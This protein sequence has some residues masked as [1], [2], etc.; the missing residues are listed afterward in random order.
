MAV[1]LLISGMANTGKTTLLKTLED[2]FVVAR[3][4]KRYPFA[5]PHT[6]IPDLIYKP[7]AEEAPEHERMTVSE[8]LIDI[9]NTKLIKYKE[10]NDKMPSTIVFDSISKIFLDIES[11][12]MA[13]VDSF[14]YG[15]INTE[16]AM[17]V[18]YIE[19]TLIPYGIN[20]V[21]VSHALKDEDADTYKLVNAGGQYGKKGGFLSE[22]DNAIFIEAKGTKRIIHNRSLKFISRTLNEDLPDNMP[23]ADYNLQDHINLLTGMGDAAAE[24]EY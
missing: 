1:K 24:F 4:G 7:S 21:I 13:K 17:L 6:N 23:V 12:V 16:I 14:P 10:K 22:V 9:I 19:N 3:D 11:A 5:Q 15:V 18:N 20:V 8:Q 2:V